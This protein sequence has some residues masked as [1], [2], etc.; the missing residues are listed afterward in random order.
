[1]RKTLSAQFF[2][3]HCDQKKVITETLSNIVSETKRLFS[4]IHSVRHLLIFGK[5][6]GTLRIDF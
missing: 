1:M 6:K 3:H 4:S 2:M 5:Q